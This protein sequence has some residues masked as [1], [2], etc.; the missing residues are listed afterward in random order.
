L[1]EYRL[2]PAAQRDLESIFDHT[3]RQWGVTQAVRYTQ[4]LESA[5]SALA[6]APGK[7]QDCGNIRSGYRRRGVG[8]H[9]IYFRV[10]DYGIA[11]IRIL[12][13]RMDSS[14]HLGTME[15]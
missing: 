10:T 4:V 6:E 11:V 2:S 9:S 12:H 14:R 8:K 3:V 15:P 1:A 7:A 13:T 5:F